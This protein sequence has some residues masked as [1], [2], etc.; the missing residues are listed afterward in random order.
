MWDRGVTFVDQ[1]SA[2]AV[3]LEKVQL[4]NNPTHRDL[5]ARLVHQRWITEKDHIHKS[6]NPCNEIPDGQQRWRVR[7]GS[8]HFRTICC[9]LYCLALSTV[10]CAERAC[11]CKSLGNGFF[12][13]PPPLLT[14]PLVLDECAGLTGFNCSAE[15]PF[16]VPHPW[17]AASC[18]GAPL[19]N[20]AY[21]GIECIW[22]FR[23]N[24]GWRPFISLASSVPTR[25]TSSLFG[26][27][28]GLQ[29]IHKKNDWSL[30]A[31]RLC[32]M[33]IY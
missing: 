12:F 28:C 1:R 5:T 21:Y 4:R 20:Q 30:L 14:L 8:F 9:G 7:W 29:E 6:L 17:S 2:N 19:P 22:P 33:N 18:Q 3:T 13:R 10:H 31:V 16:P 32:D 23:K 25:K 11:T 15:W 26:F 27:H 24:N